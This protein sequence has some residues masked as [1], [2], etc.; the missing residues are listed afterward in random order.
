MIL[1][2]RHV[3]F[4]TDLSED[5]QIAWM[6]A[7]K[8]AL[9][10]RGHLTM[11]H[12]LRSGEWIDWSGLPTVRELLWQWGVLRPEA[13]REDFA[14]LGI[15]VQL[16]AVRD[17]GIVRGVLDELRDND[18]DLIVM[19]AHPRDAVDRWLRPSVSKPIA[20]RAGVPSLMLPPSARPIVNAE[21]G[22]VGLHRFLLAIGSEDDQQRAVNAAVALAKAFGVQHC[23]GTLLHAGIAENMPALELHHEGWTWDVEVAAAPVVAA[24]REAADRLRPDVVVLG[25]HRHDEPLDVMIGS[26]AER[27]LYQVECPVLFV[28]VR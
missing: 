10:G 26:I 18:V 28:P 20:R 16:H 4:P 5:N 6:H 24:I 1:P 15:H 27:V 13:T 2:F 22:A 25:T 21:T 3:L 14:A 12:V 19:Q 23:H 17:M 9:L 11:V 7:V 8:L